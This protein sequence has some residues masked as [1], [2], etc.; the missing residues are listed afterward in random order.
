MSN[1]NI[2]KL[3]KESAKSK[4]I[5][6]HWF[7]PVDKGS[8]MP[9]W[10]YK[11]QVEEEHDW[12]ATAE[13]QLRDD[14]VPTERIREVKAELRNRKERHEQ[15]LAANR[16]VKKEISGNAALRDKAAK[17]FGELAEIIKDSLFTRDEMFNKPTRLAS[18]RDEAERTQFRNNVIKEY[19]IIGSILGEDSNPERLRKGR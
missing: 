18:P 2:H 14:L 12:I 13:K 19:K 8:S 5:I 15:I 16:D 3:E 4:E 11:Q 1:R 6:S 10:Y 17:R 7:K 9:S